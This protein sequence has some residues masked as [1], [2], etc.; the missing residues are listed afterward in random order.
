MSRH[1][2]LRS[3]SFRKMRITQ[4][5]TRGIDK[6]PDE[7]KIWSHR[8]LTNMSTERNRVVVHFTGGKLLKGYTHDFT[9]AKDTFH[10][11]SEQE[12]DKGQVHEVKLAELKAV[13]FVKTLEGDKDYVEKKR[14]EEVD[15]ARL[16]GLKIRVEFYDGEIMR[17]ISL[18]Y[19]KNRPGFFIVPVDPEWNNERVYV[20]ARALRDIKVGSAAE[21]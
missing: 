15:Q 5:R 16:H 19:S 12:S 21:K 14:F 3:E 7:R 10:V 13:F 18:G 2:A 8:K 1:T 6:K 20:L 4:S 9:P 17:G 11:T